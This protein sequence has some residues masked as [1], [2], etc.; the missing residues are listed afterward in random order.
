MVVNNNILR[1]TSL[2]QFH[3]VEASKLNLMVRVQLTGAGD[4]PLVWVD[5]GHRDLQFL[6]SC[7]PRH[8]QADVTTSAAYIEH[9][10][11]PSFV[12]HPSGNWSDE[13]IKDQRPA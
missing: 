12:I 7:T 4:S 2:N 6:H 11:L 9:A 1:D 13:R 8:H 10:Q 5:S 3:R